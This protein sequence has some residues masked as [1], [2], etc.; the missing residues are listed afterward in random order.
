MMNAGSLAVTGSWYG[1]WSWP[2]TSRA[3]FTI[4]AAQ[5]DDNDDSFCCFIGI[6][7]ASSGEDKSFRDKFYLLIFY[8]YMYIVYDDRSGNA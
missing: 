5:P 8:N 2:L 3:V 7:L 4:W 6:S 1:V